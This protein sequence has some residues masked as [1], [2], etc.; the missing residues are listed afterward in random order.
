MSYITSMIAGPYGPNGMRLW[1]TACGGCGRRT[2]CTALLPDAAVVTG[3]IRC[4]M[5]IW[6]EEVLR[7]LRFPVKAK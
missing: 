4:L 1:L 7:R 3:V 5:C 6:R 2:Y